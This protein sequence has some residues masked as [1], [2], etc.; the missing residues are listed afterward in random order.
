MNA[1][2]EIRRRIAAGVLALAA[3]A[4]A[5][6]FY[7]QSLLDDT[8]PVRR[9][10]PISELKP[11]P[12][13]GAV[14]VVPEAMRAAKWRRT[15]ARV[16]ELGRALPL[17]VE[18]EGL[19]TSQGRGRFCVKGER[20]WFSAT[21]NSSP[22]NN[23]RSYEF[24]VYRPVHKPAIIA[25]G[26]AAIV[27]GLGICFLPLRSW[28]LRLVRSGSGQ[29]A[30]RARL[31]R[32]VGV[33]CLS[34]A[35]LALLLPFTG[36][37]RQV[38]IPPADML[39]QPEGHFCYY[40]ARWIRR[41]PFRVES[42]RLFE[43]HKQL[44]GVALP[45]VRQA[46][47]P[48]S[49]VCTEDYVCFRA[50]DLSAPSANG[51][52]Y[53]L[54]V[55][56]FA[57]QPLLGWSLFFGSIGLL[58]T[59]YSRRGTTAGGWQANF[60]LASWWLSVSVLSLC[61]LWVVAGEDSMA[62][63][64]DGWSYAI[65]TTRMIWGEDGALPSH[66]AGFPFIA[67][68]VA[69]FG[70][71][72]RMGLELLYLGACAYVARRLIS[73]AGSR[74]AG[75]MAFL[76]LAWH[77]W[78]LSGFRDYMSDPVMTVLLLALLGSMF[79]ILRRPATEWTWPAFAQTGGILFL[80]EWSRQEGPLV[81]ASYG[82]FVALAVAAAR[83]DTNRKGQDIRRMA[84]LLAAPLVIVIGLSTAVKGIY[85]QQSG[86]F[87]K[88]S[89]HSAGLSK[90]MDALYRIKPE[91]ELRY[92]PVT[93]QS[94]RAACEASLTLKRFE[95]VLLNPDAGATHLG[96]SMSKIPG[97]FGSCLHWLLLTSLPGDRRPS[98]I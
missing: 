45:D 83:R 30:E 92:A 72:W 17:R 55:F 35:G 19:V 71:P 96:E 77:P 15:G 1:R 36:L 95:G 87:A 74:L 28:L 5:L 9:P 84:V 51:R 26:L 24:E 61:K 62:Q 10:I 89:Q 2:T 85:Y 67:G 37:S 88:A 63:S 20:L 46:S 43:D 38:L 50:T 93:R 39:Q 4:G 47:A 48:G 79:G 94:L 14:W 60:G 44:R 49:Y 75:L 90:L 86:V 66:P 11:G 31:C 82:L 23:G 69:Q 34:L 29:A 70:L 40:L 8:T 22:L 6:F 18:E 42:A 78:T 32:L 64:E 12:G 73:L 25:V 98:R 54:K 52:T 68:L 13:F 76:V 53:S 21:D 65:S 80:W 33:C 56:F 59:G 91:Q 3:L 97:E 16:W 58:L 57:R 7:W 27:A 81:Y 41:D